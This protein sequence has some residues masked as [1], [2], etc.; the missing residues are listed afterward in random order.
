MFTLEYGVTDLPCSL[1]DF[2]SSG[3][4]FALIYL[5]PCPVLLVIKD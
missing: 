3:D 5:N 2:P 1:R 4:G